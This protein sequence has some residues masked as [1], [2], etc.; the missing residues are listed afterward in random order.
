MIDVWWQRK[1]HGKCWCFISLKRCGMKVRA[2]TGMKLTVWDR[3]SPVCTNRYDHRILKARDSE[4]SRVIC[5]GCLAP[6]STVYV[7]IYYAG[8]ARRLGLGDHWL[9]P[10]QGQ[11]WAE[12]TKRR[13]RYYT[14]QVYGRGSRNPGGEYYENTNV[15]TNFLAFHGTVNVTGGNRTGVLSHYQSLSYHRRFC[16]Y[17][18]HHHG[19]YNYLFIKTRTHARH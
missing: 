10:A 15:Q 9:G 13:W 12:A 19:V 3:L 4:Q 14:V 7:P 2:F 17:C 11:A 1:H 6:V 16:C 5:T 18:F 8:S